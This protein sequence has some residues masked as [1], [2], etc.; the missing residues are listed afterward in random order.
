MAL[1]IRPV[2]SDRKHEA[3][4]RIFGYETIPV[5]SPHSLEINWSRVHYEYKEGAPTLQLQLHGVSAADIPLRI[6]GTIM[7]FL[8]AFEKFYKSIFDILF[9]D[10][11][12]RYMERALEPSN[13]SSKF[14]EAI[15]KIDKKHRHWGAI[16]RCIRDIFLL[17]R[18]QTEIFK[19]LFATRPRSGEDADRFAYRIK[20]MFRAANIPEMEKI[21]ITKIHVELPDLGQERVRNH[22]KSV[23]DIPS[24]DMLLGFICDH[25]S[26][27]R[28]HWTDPIAWIRNMFSDNGT[29]S[30]GQSRRNH[31][32]SSPGSLRARSH[33]RNRGRGPKRQA[34]Y[35][36]A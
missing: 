27:L 25:P 30:D 23:E 10:V 33:R 6:I 35:R 26:L 11:A 14:D 2:L 32:R 28:G 36:R 13:M 1:D 16:E 22:F 29:E 19:D 18:M 20:T 7:D 8:D 24:L 9:D 15:M 34:P 4:A 31:S 21:I 17:N 3:V 5:V 12:W